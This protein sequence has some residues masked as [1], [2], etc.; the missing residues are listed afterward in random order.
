MTTSGLQLLWQHNCL[1]QY[2]VGWLGVFFSSLPVA[3]PDYLKIT[4]GCDNPY[5]GDEMV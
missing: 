1:S 5:I 3:E 2:F 4:F